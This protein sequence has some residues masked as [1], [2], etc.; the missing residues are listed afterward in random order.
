[1]AP[2]QRHELPAASASSTPHP[3][4]ARLQDRLRCV[5]DTSAPTARCPRREASAPPQSRAHARPSSGAS[6]CPVMGNGVKK[7]PFGTFAAE[8]RQCVPHAD[9]HLLREIVLIR[10]PC[11]ARDD[12]PECRPVLLHQPGKS[13]FVRGHIPVV[14]CKGET[15]HGR[16]RFGCGPTG[17]TALREACHI[18]PTSSLDRRR[19]SRPRSRW[20]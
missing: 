3:G 10:R 12:P 15:L 14:P 9:A 7:G 2:R 17:G 19:P 8:P 18:E 5:R 20:H 1:L 16:R 13:L 4:R 11:V 6:F